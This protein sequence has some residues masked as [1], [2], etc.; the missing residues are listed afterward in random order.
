MHS[1][2]FALSR[3]VSSSCGAGGA[4]DGVGVRDALV[5][6]AEQVRADGGAKSQ[7]LARATHPSPRG[8]RAPS[9]GPSQG[10]APR[11]QTARVRETGAQTVHRS[12][13]DAAQ[14]AEGVSFARY[15]VSDPA[16]LR[17]LLQCTT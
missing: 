9:Q 17:E 16:G 13:A 12:N 15:K 14:V 7:G 2:L 1:D 5:H 6:D 4:R 11:A 8:A 10:A 3:S